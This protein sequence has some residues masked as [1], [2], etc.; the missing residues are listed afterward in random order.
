VNDVFEDGWDFGD[1]LSYLLGT[2]KGAGLRGLRSGVRAGVMTALGGPD[3]SQP[4]A[5]ATEAARGVGP[6][7]LGAAA[8]VALAVV[9]SRSR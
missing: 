9:A 5:I 2:E 3:V 4:R 1:G 6:Y 8:I 7:V